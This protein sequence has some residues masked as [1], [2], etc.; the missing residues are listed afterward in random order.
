MLACSEIHNDKVSDI[1]PL[2]GMEASTGFDPRSGPFAYS[3]LARDAS[4]EI[5]E[6]A[7]HVM[8]VD[9]LLRSSQFAS[10]GIHVDN[11]HGALPCTFLALGLG[12]GLGFRF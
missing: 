2:Q 1:S 6:V 4:V 10:G 9:D 8:N 7:E 3:P 11:F 12:L 5:D